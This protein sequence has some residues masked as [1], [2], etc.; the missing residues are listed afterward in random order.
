MMPTRPCTLREVHSYVEYGGMGPRLG[1]GPGPAWVCGFPPHHKYVL[2]YLN[3]GMRTPASGYTGFEADFLGG[4]G[5]PG[6]GRAWVRSGAGL[7]AWIAIG[8]LSHMCTNIYIYIY[9][10]FPF[11]FFSIY[12]YNII[13]VCV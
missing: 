1:P 2:V 8:L 6:A 13:F 3:F 9:F 10:F 5:G 12:L 7:I 4:A 11:L